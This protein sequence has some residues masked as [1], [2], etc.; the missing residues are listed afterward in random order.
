MLYIN[1]S[2]D[3]FLEDLNR[4]LRHATDHLLE[5]GGSEEGEQRHGN[6]EGHSLPHGRHLNKCHQS[7]S[8]PTTKCGQARNITNNLVDVTTS[9]LTAAPTRTRGNTHRYSQ[10]F[11]RIRAYKHSFFRSTIKSWNKCTQQLV[12][13]QSLDSFRRHLHSV[14]IKVHIYVL[15]S[16]TPSQ[17]HPLRATDQAR[18]Y[19]SHV[20]T[21]L[22]Q[23]AGL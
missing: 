14:P 13:K 23:S 1:N 9:A 17:H 6:N 18:Q 10:P 12:S 5:V 8:T 3:N 15:L 16:P 21:W 2:P 11:T 19:S 20:Y 4:H 7:H 22:L